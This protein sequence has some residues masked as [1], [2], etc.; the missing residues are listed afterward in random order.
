MD[1]AMI[2]KFL[3]EKKPLKTIKH[4]LNLNKN[5]EKKEEVAHGKHV[6]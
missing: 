1:K 5:K 6:R 4:P 3:E 2:K